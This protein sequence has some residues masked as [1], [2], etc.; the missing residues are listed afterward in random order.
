MSSVPIGAHVSRQR[1]L[2]AAAAFCRGRS[3]EPAAVL[4]VGF[5][6]LR[7]AGALTP[8]AQAGIGAWSALQDLWILTAAI[9]L[10]A[11]PIRS[12]RPSS[13]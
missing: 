6:L 7:L 2:A 8:L 13:P 11:R 10:L 9:T 5:L 1:P 3:R 12:G 4:A